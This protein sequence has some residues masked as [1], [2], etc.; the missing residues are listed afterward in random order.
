MESIHILLK[1]KIQLCV[2]CLL[3]VNVSVAAD[4]SVLDLEKWYAESY[5]SLWL[6]DPWN[7]R[8]E[9]L[10]FY[11]SEIYIHASEGEIISLKTSTWMADLLNEWVAD[12]W[13][14]SE[15]PDI[16]VNRINE[17]TA[18]FT[19]RWLDHYKDR[20]AE[21]SCAWYLA[22]LMDDRWKFT[23]FAPIDCASHGF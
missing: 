17:S 7:K 13:V 11:H 18:S 12:G 16:R 21:Y 23:H 10:G 15:V 1:S 9:I 19:T 5:G 2:C 14:S 6:E 22:D 4:F 8:D 20:D 3:N